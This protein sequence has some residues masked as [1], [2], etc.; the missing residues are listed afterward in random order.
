M[1]KERVRSF[2]MVLLLIGL[3]ISA[4][5]FNHLPACM[6]FATWMIAGELEYARKDS[7]DES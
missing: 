5:V 4:F 3:G 1:N 2:F 7:T 6:F